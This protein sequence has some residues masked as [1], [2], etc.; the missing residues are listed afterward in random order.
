[1]SRSLKEIVAR[2]GGELKGDGNLV[3]TGLATLDKASPGQLSF[4]ANPKYFS[5]LASTRA[6]AVILVPEMAGGCPVAA[7]VTPQ[8]Y[9]Y[10]ARASQWLAPKPAHPSGIHASAVVESTL[11][12]SVSVGPQVCIGPEVEIGANVVIEAQCRIG[13]GVRIGADSHLYPVAICIR[14]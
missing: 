4:L 5:Q 1:V 13:A 8:P 7:I 2:F 10:F 12:S 11:P 3:V 6:G 9:L 14:V